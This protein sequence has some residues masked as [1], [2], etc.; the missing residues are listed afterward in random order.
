M[1]IRY[2]NLNRFA[3]TLLKSG[4]F[5]LL[6]L[7]KLA[8]KNRDTYEYIR[9][10]HKGTDILPL[11]NGAGGKIA[12]FGMFGMGGRKMISRI[13][14]KQA[15]F[16]KLCNLFQYDCLDLSEFRN[17]SE[18]TC[19]ELFEFLKKCENLGFAELSHGKFRL[20]LNGV[21]WGNNI[22]VNCANII[23]KEFIK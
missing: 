17:L 12:G 20:N 21:F 13:L 2:A 23:K 5:E 11:G 7:T 9:H 3:K 19:N 10:T 4:E 18:Q 14:P 15:E 16:E 1:Q 8:R 6:E 22:A